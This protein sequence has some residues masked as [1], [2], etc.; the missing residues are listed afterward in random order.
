ML[1]KMFANGSLVCGRAGFLEEI[2]SDPQES[3]RKV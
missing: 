3:G 1:F 2:V